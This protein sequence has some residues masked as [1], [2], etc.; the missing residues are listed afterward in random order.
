MKTSKALK[1]KISKITIP[2]RPEIYEPPVPLDFVP[3][4]VDLSPSALYTC[5]VGCRK[6]AGMKTPELKWISVKRWVNISPTGSVPLPPG[7]YLSIKRRETF[8]AFP[9]PKF[10]KEDY[11]L[12]MLP[13]GNIVFTD[14]EGK[15]FEESYLWIESNG[16]TN[17]ESLLEN[18]INNPLPGYF[19]SCYDYM[20]KN[21]DQIGIHLKRKKP[22]MSEDLV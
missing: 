16:I 20:Q 4:E 1:E 17:F 2:L 3:W 21:P 14:L 9:A 18:D 7:C 10:K 19:Q 11:M 6:S 15:P 22:S 12:V 5:S 13:Y 8:E